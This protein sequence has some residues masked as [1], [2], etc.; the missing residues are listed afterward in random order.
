M[1]VNSIAGSLSKI[2]HALENNVFQPLKLSKNHFH[3]KFAPKLLFLIEKKKD[4]DKN[5]KIHFENQ[6]LAKDLAF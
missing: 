6:I 2:G 1:F 5:K 4:S 3:K